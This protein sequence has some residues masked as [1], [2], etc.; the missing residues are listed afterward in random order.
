MDPLTIWRCKNLDE[1][2]EVP[3]DYGTSLGY[4]PGSQVL[5]NMEINAM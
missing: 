5:A 2:I 4:L 1:V 3:Q